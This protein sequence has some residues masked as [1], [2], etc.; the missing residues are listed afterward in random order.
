MKGIPERCTKCG[1]DLSNVVVRYLYEGVDCKP[2]FEYTCGG[3]GAEFEIEVAAIPQFLC[4]LKDGLTPHAADRACAP[5]GNDDA[6]SDVEDE[7]V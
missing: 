3:C 4:T 6:E 5:A 2:Y 1:T 7:V